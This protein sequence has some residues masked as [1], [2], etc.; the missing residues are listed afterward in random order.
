M[1]CSWCGVEIG[2]DQGYRALEPAG[3]RRAAFCRLEHVVP[4]VLQGARWGAASDG[5]PADETAG[6]PCAQCGEAAGDTRVVLVRHRDAHRI[7]DVFCVTDHLRRW[8]QA[9][10]RW[11]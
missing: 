11:Q 8:A 3:L 7:A 9:G 6:E 5:G 4:W 10:G 2:E 1:V